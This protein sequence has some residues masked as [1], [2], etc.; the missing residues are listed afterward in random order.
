MQSISQNFFYNG[1]F[2][3]K[4]NSLTKIDEF[5]TGKISYFIRCFYFT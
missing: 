4:L 3:F 5:M 2:R 1:K